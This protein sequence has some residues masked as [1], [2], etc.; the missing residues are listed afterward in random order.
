MDYTLSDDSLSLMDE[1]DSFV[2]VVEPKTNTLMYLNKKMNMNS[3][4][5]Y[6]V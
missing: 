5:D 3:K 2:Y 4:G 1:V 6:T